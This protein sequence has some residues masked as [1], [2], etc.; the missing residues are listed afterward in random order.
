MSKTEIIEARI[1]EAIYSD[2]EDRGL[3]NG[4]GRDMHGEIREGWRAS[5]RLALEVLAPAVRLAEAYRD[6]VNE[7]SRVPKDSAALLASYER[8][9]AAFR[10]YITASAQPARDPLKEL[11]IVLG[12]MP[13]SDNV[14]RAQALLAQAI[15]RRA[16]K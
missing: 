9:A 3:F 4:I 10:A 12:C 5:I 14:T 11:A 16:G 1:L 8:K 13:G 2:A 6:H 7:T 15:E